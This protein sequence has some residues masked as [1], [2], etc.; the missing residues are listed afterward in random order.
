MSGKASARNTAILVVGMHRSGTS[1]LTRVINLLG[2]NL[3]GSLLGPG[4]GN[5][6]GHWENT[7]AIAINDAVLGGLGLSWDDTQPLPQDWVHSAGARQAVRRIST[8]IAHEFAD[9]P[10]WALKDP[11]LCRLL[12]IWLDALERSNVDVRIVF[13][14]RH[15]GEV[16]ESLNFRDGL[17]MASS[18]LRWLQHIAEAELATRGC[19]RTVVL[20]GDLLEDWR[21]VVGRMG[22][23]LGIRWPVMPAVVATDVDAFLSPVERHYSAT[24]HTAPDLLRAPAMLYSAFAA[25]ARGE[26]GW[27]PV[28]SL[29]DTYQLWSPSFLCDIRRRGEEATVLADR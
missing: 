24:D 2:A 3:G 15:S 26:D 18:Q 27:G 1:A 25:C 28:S 20:Y 14:I 16:A 7:E 8:L 11:R 4:K 19:R 21:K 22:A 29:V 6:K 13:S 12:P 9:S 5:A 10:L 23:G 17:D